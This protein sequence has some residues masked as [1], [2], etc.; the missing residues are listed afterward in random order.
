MGP[1]N[2]DYSYS[3]LG[4]ILESFEFG[5]LMRYELYRNYVGGLWGYTGLM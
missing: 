1:H 4:S 3:I 2:T 5:K